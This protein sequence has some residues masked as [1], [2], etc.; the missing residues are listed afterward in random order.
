MA[1]QPASPNWLGRPQSEGRWPSHSGL[2]ITSAPNAATSPWRHRLQKDHAKV[3]KATAQRYYQL[4]TGH[5]AIG[6]FLH[7]RMTGPQRLDSDRV[8]GA[9]AERANGATTS[10]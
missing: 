7:N 2:E 4:L 8:G 9:T 1:D 5:A 10:S 6:S 3:R